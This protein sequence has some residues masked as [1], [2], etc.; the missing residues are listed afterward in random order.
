MNDSD[1]P[2]FCS[3]CGTILELIPSP[4]DCNSPISFT[5]GVLGF[6]NTLAVCPNFDCD[7]YR[8]VKAVN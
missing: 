4:L 7:L 3:K 2:L 6:N 5:L 1:K 8:I